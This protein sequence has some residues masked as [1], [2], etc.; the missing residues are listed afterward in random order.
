MHFNWGS[1]IYVGNKIMAHI[2]L[3]NNDKATIFGFIKF[4]FLKSVVMMTLGDTTL[5]LSMQIRLLF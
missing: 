1:L 2:F 3:S 4:I 5:L